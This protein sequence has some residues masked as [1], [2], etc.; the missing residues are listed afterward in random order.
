MGDCRRLS[1]NRLG[2]C[3]VTAGVSRVGAAFH[4]GSTTQRLFEIIAS[5]NAQERC[6]VEQ[7]DISSDESIT[8]FIGRL[9]IALGKGMML[10]NVV[11]NAGVLKYQGRATEVSF[12][13]FALHLHTNTVGPI[14]GARKLLDPSVDYPP[15]KIIFI[16][17]DS[18]SAT[19]FL[20][21]E[22]EFGAFAA[23]KSALNQILRHMAAELQRS[24]QKKRGTVILA[25]HPGGPGWEVKGSISPSESVSAILHVVSEKGEGDSGTFWCWNG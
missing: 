11:L 19:R 8:S 25:L 16:S 3:Q 7:C 17:S 13:D 24:D 20:D 10:G 6:I 9:R 1:R 2:V 22:D 14:I 18:G 4:N 12:S 15:P 23:S 5:K 21:F